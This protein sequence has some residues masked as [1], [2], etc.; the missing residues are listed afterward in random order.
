MVVLTERL[1]CY[2]VLIS[3][4]EGEKIINEMKQTGTK[5]SVQANTALLKGNEVVV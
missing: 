5:I 4:Q 3:T 2:S 1:Y